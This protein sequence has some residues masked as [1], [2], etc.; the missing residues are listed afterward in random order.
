MSNH[1][2]LLTVLTMTS[3]R[4]IPGVWRVAWK[5]EPNVPSNKV[6]PM[7]ILFRWI[8]NDGFSSAIIWWAPGS[9]TYNVATPASSVHDAWTGEYTA[10]PLLGAIVLD[11]WIFM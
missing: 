5:M 11:R 3:L 8:R 9:L 10:V 6:F 1:A 7:T 4:G 2:L